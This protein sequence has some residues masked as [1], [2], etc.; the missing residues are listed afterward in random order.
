V[1]GSIKHDLTP[2][3]LRAAVRKFAEVYVQ[4]FAEYKA[5]AQWLSDDLVEVHFKVKGVRLA[6]RLELKPRELGLDMSVP[7]PFQLFK[8]RA[9]KAIEEE[10][11]PWLER[12]KRGELT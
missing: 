10:V 3:Q 6:G 4:R 12:A 2:D 1:K 8:N 5:D 9:L 7:L 11:T